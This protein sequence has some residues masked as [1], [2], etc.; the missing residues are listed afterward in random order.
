MGEEGWVRDDGAGHKL[1]RSGR[2][3]S[4]KKRQIESR[5]DDGRLR[6]LELAPRVEAVHASLWLPI[7]G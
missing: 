7:E 1:G 3:E 4:E 6:H 5:A 2:K